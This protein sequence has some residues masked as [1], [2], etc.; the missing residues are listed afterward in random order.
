MKGVTITLKG[1]SY[2]LHQSLKEQAKRHKRSLNQEAIQCLENALA[3]PQQDRPS[4]GQSP[5]P[6]SVGTILLPLGDRAE[7]PADMLERAP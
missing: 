7:R 1:G 2:E 4:L 3:E 5:Q 6:V